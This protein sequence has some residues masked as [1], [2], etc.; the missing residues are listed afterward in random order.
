MSERILRQELKAA[1]QEIERLRLSLKELRHRCLNEWQ[2][3]TAI[4]ENEAHTHQGSIPKD[5]LVRVLVY[6]QAVAEAHYLLGQT[7]LPESERV[8]LKA[9]L[10]SL[11]SLLQVTHHEHRFCLEIDEA[12]LPQRQCLS[13]A[14]ICSELVCNAVKHGA[15]RTTVCFRVHERHAYFTVSD[16]GPGFPADFDPR[17]SANTGIDVVETLCRS[18]LGGQVKYANGRGAEVTMTFPLL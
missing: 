18:D 16:D 2:A 5:S 11:C 12:T 14:L 10:V 7:S 4:V 13:L 8:P 3:L 15:S 6:T 17:I 1:W 9:L